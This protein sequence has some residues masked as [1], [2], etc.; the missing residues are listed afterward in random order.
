MAL[1]SGSWS[2]SICPVSLDV[3]LSYCIGTD[4]SISTHISAI[5]DRNFVQLGPSRTLIPQ[6]LV[7]FTS[8]CLV[9]NQIANRS[10]C[11]GIVLIHGYYKIDPDLAI[12]T[13]RAAVEKQ[14]GLIAKVGIVRI[15]CILG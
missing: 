4:A 7:L 13:M 8:C 12:P 15:F 5:V 6:P 14:L 9:C 11:Q 10:F 2:T 3:L 1:V